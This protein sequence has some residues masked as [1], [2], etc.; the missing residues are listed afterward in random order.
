[1]AETRPSVATAAGQ[2]PAT[3]VYLLLS[4]GTPVDDDN[5]LPGAGGG[6]GGSFD[7]TI[8]DGADVAQGTTT[9][10]PWDLENAQATLIALMKAM[11]VNGIPIRSNPSN[12]LVNFEA[13]ST[14]AWEGREYEIVGLSDTDEPLG[15][16]GAVGDVLDAIEVH[17]S[18]VS[19]AGSIV[20]KDGGTTFRTITAAEMPGA[21]GKFFYFMSAKSKNGGWTVSTPADVTATA[22][23]MWAP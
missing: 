4:D 19:P 13:A 3:P 21:V 5:P 22:Y 1:M 17:P 6:G 20:I 16:A 2:V 7:G 12:D 8:A 15:S 18:D 10:D 23:G 14:V 11:L 9:D